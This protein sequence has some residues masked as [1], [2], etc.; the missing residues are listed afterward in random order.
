MQNRKDKNACPFCESKENLF[1]F[2][3]NDYDIYECSTCHVEFVSPMPS[4]VILENY[5]NESNYH[6]GSRYEIERVTE[7]DV[8][9]W[10][11]R[12]SH[13]RSLGYDS[14][15]VLDVGCATGVFLYTMAKEGWETKGIE[16][17][18]NAF[19]LANELL[20]GDSVENIDLL[21]FSTG[22]K[23][24]VISM[25]AVLEHIP[26]PRDYLRKI[27]QLLKKDG[28]FAISTPN[29]NSLSRLIY[30]RRWRYYNPPE[31]VL[32]FKAKSLNRVLED[33]GLTVVSVKSQ[34]NFAAYF[35]KGSCI[36]KFYK[37]SLPFRVIVKSIFVPLILLNKWY[38]IGETL[39]L[40]ARKK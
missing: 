21:E 5:Y 39:E 40:Y 30:H 16:L 17:S 24:D 18:S 20:D 28:L 11:R 25:W 2:A 19:R 29:T 22:S 26:H 27:H 31:H 7:S 33:L 38:A 35:I 8:R 9:V 13:I 1:R 12:S 23:Y 36:E 10:E 6:S 32:F 15:T 34:F 3:K 4:S 14:G 37:K